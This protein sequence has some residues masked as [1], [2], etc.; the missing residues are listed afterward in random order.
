MMMLLL[1]FM[2]PLAETSEER[3]ALSVCAAVVCEDIH[4]ES[5]L[6]KIN[7]FYMGALHLHATDKH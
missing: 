3:R 7:S 5:L 6:Q 1:S 4:W 2:L